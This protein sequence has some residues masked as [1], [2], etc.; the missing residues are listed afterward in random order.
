MSTV[1]TTIDVAISTCIAELVAIDEVGFV[2]TYTAT[3]Y[4]ICHLVVVSSITNIQY[5]SSTRR[6][7]HQHLSRL[8]KRFM[9]ALILFQ[10]M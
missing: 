3:C 10:T 6:Q 2:M 8:K 7:E 9:R 1:S 5:I 4:S